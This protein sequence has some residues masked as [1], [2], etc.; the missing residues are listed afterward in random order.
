MSVRAALAAGAWVGLALG[1]VLGAVLGALLVWFAGAVVDWQRDLA[2]TLGV[3]RRLLPFGDQIGLLRDIE[4][5]WWLV[6]PAIAVLVSALFAAIGALLGGIFAA[7]YNRSP[8][9]A[10][11]VVELP[12]AVVRPTHSGP[13]EGS[14]GQD[15]VLH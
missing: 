1:L 13:E 14:T 6:V 12:E 15:R 4:S 10:L 3:A 7:I 11:I 5:R 2:F 8:R 9:H